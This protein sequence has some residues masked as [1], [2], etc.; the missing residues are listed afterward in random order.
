MKEDTSAS[1]ILTRRL[2]EKRP[3]GRSRRRW[4]DNIRMD[5]NE[6]GINTKSWV[7]SAQDRDY[8]EPP[9]SICH[10]IS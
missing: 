6:T 2:T 5:F 7:D 3:S 4:E 10:G 1:K 8:C 9:V